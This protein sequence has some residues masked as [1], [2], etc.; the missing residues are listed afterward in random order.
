MIHPHVL[1]LIFSSVLVFACLF[2]IIL[3]LRFKPE[4]RRRSMYVVTS[5]W[6]AQATVAVFYVL[7]HLQ[8]NGQSLTPSG[9]TLVVLETIF[10]ISY[11]FFL[12]NYLRA[13]RLHKPRQ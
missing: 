3:A 7:P 6:C 5:I 2:Q 13:S 12:G 4:D 1:E 8:P 9:L 11:L 10:A